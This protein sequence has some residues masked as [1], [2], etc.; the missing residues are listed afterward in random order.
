EHRVIIDSGHWEE[1]IRWI[2]KT[3]YSGNTVS[4]LDSLAQKV[5]PYNIS[6]AEN[7][8]M[9][10]PPL[11]IPAMT[12]E[13]TDLHTFYVAVSPGLHAQQ[14]SRTNNFFKDSVLHGKFADGKQILDGDDYIQVTQRLVRQDSGTTVIETSFLP[15]DHPGIKPLLDTIGKKTFDHP[16]NFQM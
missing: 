14:L 15:P 11:V 10:L 9:Q 13:I 3:V 5:T 2:S 6:L 16:N 1:V 8:K 12:G 7:G 4:H